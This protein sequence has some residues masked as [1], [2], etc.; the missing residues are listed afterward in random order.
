[1]M[2]VWKTY[3][4]IKCPNMKIV[5]LFKTHTHTHPHTEKDRQTDRDIQT[6]SKR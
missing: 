3:T 6:E 1:M 5:K 2:N 4:W